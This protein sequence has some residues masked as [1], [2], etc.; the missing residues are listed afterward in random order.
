MF[1]KGDDYPAARLTTTRTDNPKVRQV[2]AIYI[3]DPKADGWGP[4]LSDIAMELTTAS[5]KWLTMDRSEAS[6]SAQKLWQ[7]YKDHRLGDDVT[8]LQLDDHQNFLTPEDDDNIDTRM[9]EDQLW[10]SR[11]GRFMNMAQNDEER[12]NVRRNFYNRN[13]L[14]WAFK[15][16]EE[17]LPALRGMKGVLE[18]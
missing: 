13:A 5:G 16:E 3:D 6:P 11:Y 17:V 12:S 15:K 7:F 2:G 10:A 18:E 1:W 9:A 14:M 8:G 4:F